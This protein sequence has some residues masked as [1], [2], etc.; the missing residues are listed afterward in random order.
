MPRIV[1]QITNEFKNEVPKKHFE[2]IGGNLQLALAIALNEDPDKIEV[3]GQVPFFTLNPLP[4]TVDVVFS[5][6]E[7]GFNLTWEEKEQVY[8]KLKEVLVETDKLPNGID[9][10]IWIM[11]SQGGCFYLVEKR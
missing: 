3:F 11:P 1:M 6:G 8:N 5:A 7:K 9:L 4:L 2:K 10:G